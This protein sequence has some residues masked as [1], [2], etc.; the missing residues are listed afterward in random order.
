M[1]AGATADEADEAGDDVSVER[2]I[3]AWPAG[4]P[5]AAL[6]V[7]AGAPVPAEAA[8]PAEAPVPAEAA[9]PTE[10]PVPAEVPLPV[11]RGEAPRSPGVGVRA[12]DGA[13][14]T[15]DGPTAEGDVAEVAVDADVEEERATAAAPADGPTGELADEP[16]GELADGPAGELADEP[17]G[18]LPRY[19]GLEAAGAPMTALA[20]PGADDV[21]LDGPAVDGPAVDD[22]TA[23][24]AAATAAAAAD[25]GATQ[26]R[27]DEVGSVSVPLGRSMGRA[28]VRRTA[29]ASGRWDVAAHDSVDGRTG[30][31]ANSDMACGGLPTAA[32]AA[33]A[34]RA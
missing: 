32:A 2:R 31:A 26:R 11:G 22:V 23:T 6:G 12:A 1:V 20:P 27:T 15:D 13:A 7:P 33:G 18:E 4:A 3:P 19:V 21:V 17:A 24:A 9:V 8:V 34:P 5:V 10:A 29:P 14:L 25:V 28:R 30:D 16:T